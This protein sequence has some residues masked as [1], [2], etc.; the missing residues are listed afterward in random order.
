MAHELDRLATGAAAMFSVRETPWHNEGTLL[1]GAPTFEEAL[2]LGGLDFEVEAR[3]VYFTSAEQFLRSSVGRVIVRTDRNDAKLGEVGIATVGEDYQVLQNREAFEVLTPLLDQGV[4]HLETGGSLRGGRD[5]WMLVRFDIA[6]PV[7][8]EVFGGEVVPFGVITNNHS[9]QAKARVAVTPIRIV[10]ANTL[11]MAEA[12]WRNRSTDCIE[13]SHRG[14]AR[15]RLVEAAESLFA[16][17]VERY[18][19]I[20]EQYRTMKQ[21]ILTVEAF[22]QSVLDAAA[23]MPPK[24]HQPGA[25]HITSRGYDAAYEAAT[26]RR[27]AITTKWTEGQGHTGDHSAWE[28]YNA[29]VEVIDFDAALF[30][31]RGSRVSSLL[32]GR[33]RERKQVVL[34]NV[35]RLCA[36]SEG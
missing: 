22:T 1:S 17:L 26:A 35:V 14:D 30:R 4:A 6:D 28:A 10:C 23:P 33:L 32:G 3:P 31:S 15:V 29:A 12:G 34:D 20:A 13:I 8:Q 9:G 24:A 2:R 21:T 16:G 11:G 5:V 36:T 19:T 18:R 7:V 27:V 25:E